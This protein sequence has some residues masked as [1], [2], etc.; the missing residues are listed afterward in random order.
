MEGALEA[1]EAALDQA[2]LAGSDALRV[3]HGVGTGALRRA[4]REALG[5]SP[6]VDS[7]GPAAADAGGEGATEVLLKA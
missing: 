4:V 5:S 6:Y 2:M 3:I 1:L 7:F